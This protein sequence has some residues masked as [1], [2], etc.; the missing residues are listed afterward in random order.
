[1]RDERGFT[2][3]ET[4][5]SLSILVV[6]IGLVLS[7]LR[8]GQKSW[9][10]GEEALE[11]AAARRFIVRRLSADVGSMYLYM[12]NGDGRD[13]YL[14]NAKENEFGFVTV[15]SAAGKEMPWGGASFVIYS[16]GE[17]GL[18]VTEKTVPVALTAKEQAG[19]SLELDPGISRVRF[20]YL[21]EKGWA[22]R[23][24]AE[25]IKR[26][27]RAVRVEF[28]F[29]D[30]RSPLVVTVPVG[31]TYSPSTDDSAGVKGA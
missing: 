24:D 19:R 2:L 28:I 23:W 5:L 8:L 26:L 30:D 31:V 7:S 12:E 22:R 21:G 20:E 17:N 18:T 6:M 25:S 10:K 15:K 11:D 13:T 3:I 9:E 4:I 14:F 1:M 27:P 29:R 16:A